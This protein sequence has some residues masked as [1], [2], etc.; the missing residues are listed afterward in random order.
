MTAKKKAAHA[1]PL[2]SEEELLMQRVVSLHRRFDQ[3]SE[4]QD[5]MNSDL[6]GLREKVAALLSLVDQL[7]EQNGQLVQALAE[8]AADQDDSIGV[9]MTQVDNAI[10]Q[11]QHTL[12]QAQPSQ[13]QPSQAQPSQAQSQPSQQ[14][15]TTAPPAPAPDKPKP[16]RE[17][18]QETMKRILGQQQ[19]K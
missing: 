12:S 8:A 1:E 19:K 14:R 3:F 10:S 18:A 13:A 6:S 17:S 11:A 5:S 7:V 15:T 16:P 2:V 4:R 9:I